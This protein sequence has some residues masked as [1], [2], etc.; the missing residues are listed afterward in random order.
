MSHGP[1]I[2]SCEGTDPQQKPSGKNK[3]LCHISSLKKTA[4]LYTLP[5]IVLCNLHRIKHY[6]TLESTNLWIVHI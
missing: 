4:N 1:Y 6:P 2:G 3:S 5:R